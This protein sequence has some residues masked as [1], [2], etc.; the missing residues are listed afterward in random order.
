MQNIRVVLAVSTP[1]RGGLGEGSV[2]Q[3][4]PTKCLLKRG[5]R[6]ARTLRLFYILAILMYSLYIALTQSPRFAGGFASGDSAG[7]EIHAG[8]TFFKHGDYK[9]ACNRCNPILEHFNIKELKT[10]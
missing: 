9:P 4:F 2:E 8:K 7:G 10:N 6:Q 1:P 3:T 5:L